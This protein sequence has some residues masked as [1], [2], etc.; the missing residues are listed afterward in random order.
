V[1]RTSGPMVAQAPASAGAGKQ[2]ATSLQ[3]RARRSTTARPIRPEDTELVERTTLVLRALELVEPGLPALSEQAEHASITVIGG[4]RLPALMPRAPRRLKPRGWRPAAA[5]WLFFAV[6]VVLGILAPAAIGQRIAAPRTFAPRGAIIGTVS[7][8]T[9]L[10]NA[11]ATGS[12]IA[13]LDIGGGAGPGVQAPGSAGLPV[14]T[15]KSGTPPA[16]S[17]PPSSGISPAP[18][19]P[20]PPSNPY[21]YVYVPSHRAFGMNDP[22]GYYSWAFDQCT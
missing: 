7:T 2:R 12:G 22:N 17:R 8:G 21:M 6:L 20:W 1:E 10:A 19:H 5:L 13:R 14:K 16:Q 15:T 11:W 4:A 9:S 18:V 3:A